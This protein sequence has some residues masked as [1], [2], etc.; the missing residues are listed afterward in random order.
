MTTAPLPR[1]TSPATPLLGENPRCGLEMSIRAM[2][3]A[4]SISLPPTSKLVLMA[5]ADIADDLGVCWPSHPTL[6][7]K[8]SLTDRTVRR[9]LSALQAHKL[10]FIEPRFKPTGSRTS[11]RYRLAVDI[12]P[13]KLSGGSRTPVVVGG[14]HQCPGAPDT[15]VLVTTTEPPIEPSQPP[16]PAPDRR[17]APELTG[18]GG[19]GDLFFPKDLTAGQRHVLR[20]RLTVLTPGQAQ[21]ILDELAGRVAIAQVKNPIRYCATLIVRMQRGEF[22]S[23]LGLNVADTRRATLGQIEKSATGSGPEPVVL[24]DR[25]R[26]AIRR[27]RTKSYAHSRKCK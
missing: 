16:P 8:C 26:E 3:W 21:Q 5:L 27:M 11:N 7:L 14:G 18:S 10:V 1:R 25:L 24:P 13:D 4:W 12:P 19:G 9:V 6:A 20:E 2:T 22:E 15:C 23:E 17:L